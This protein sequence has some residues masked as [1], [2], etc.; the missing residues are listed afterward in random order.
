MSKKKKQTLGEA[1]ANDLMAA[2]ACLQIVLGTPEILALVVKEIEK[3][4]TIRQNA[5]KETKPVS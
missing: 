2:Q 4:E 3:I 1:I 5:M